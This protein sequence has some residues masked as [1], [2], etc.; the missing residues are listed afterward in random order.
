MRSAVV[1]AL[2]A[3]IAALILI[4]A[5]MYVLMLPT[6]A[7]AA[8]AAT[9]RETITLYAGE[10]GDEFAFGT[11][12]DN[13]TTPGPTLR[14]RV[15]DTVQI[16]L[17]NAGNIPHSFVITDE[18]RENPLASPIFSGAAIGSASNPLGPEEEG[19]ITFTPDRPGTFYYMCTVPGHF[20]RGMYGEIIVSS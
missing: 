14:L 15:G 4:G 2:L 19:V 18:A 3:G 6:A 13:L 20:T 7:P 11:S 17:I 8:P 1:I 5:V 10:I 12:P 9:P 16:R